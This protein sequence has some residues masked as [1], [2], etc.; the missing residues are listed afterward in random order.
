MQ[1]DK[2]WLLHYPNQIP[3]ELTIPN[4]TL[5]SYLFSSAEA[6]PEHTAIHFLGK[7]ITYEQ[8][9]EDVLKLASH[10]MKIGVKKVTE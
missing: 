2:R 10:L 7:N 3:H 8:L 1:S 5:Q 6:A 4:E 9:Q